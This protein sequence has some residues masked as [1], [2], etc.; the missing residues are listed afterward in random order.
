[1]FISWIILTL[2]IYLSWW[3]WRNQNFSRKTQNRINHHL[4]EITFQFINY[5]WNVLI[6]GENNPFVNEAMGL[7]WILLIRWLLDL[8]KRRWL[9]DFNLA[10]VNF[11]IVVFR[12][13]N[14]ADWVDE[15]LF[16]MSDN[17][18]VIFVGT[19]QIWYIWST[20]LLFDLLL[21]HRDNWLQF[22][23]SKQS[24]LYLRIQSRKKTHLH[25]KVNNVMH[26]PS[27]V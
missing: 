6:R 7:E 15:T 25:S 18:P 1:M 10:V 13:F 19:Q 21:H 22:Y 27:M 17:R 9:L 4:T 23:I 11:R 3:S 16:V 14:Y 8:W 5:K 24:I 26:C 20:F 2:K 12:K